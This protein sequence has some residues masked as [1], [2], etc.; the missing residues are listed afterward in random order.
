MCKIG[1][2]NETT[3][4]SRTLCKMKYKKSRHNTIYHRNCFGAASCLGFTWFDCKAILRGDLRYQHDMSFLTVSRNV[5]PI[6]ILS[7]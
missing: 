1:W 4:T 2:H 5:G 3:E 7:C 6:A